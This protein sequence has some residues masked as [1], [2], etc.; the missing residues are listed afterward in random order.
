MCMF[1]CCVHDIHIIN[2][3]LGFKVLFAIFM[4]FWFDIP[5]S[6]MK[7]V[8]LQRMLKIFYDTIHH[9][10]QNQNEIYYDLRVT[11]LS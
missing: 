2:K 6:I 10:I 4:H 1:V 5:V 7:W 9:T 11:M 8:K 3:C